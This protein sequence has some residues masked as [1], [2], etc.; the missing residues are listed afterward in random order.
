MKIIKRIFNLP[1][2][3]F[4]FA[5]YAVLFL[6]GVNLHEITPAST[7]RSLLLSLVGA[8][9]LLLAWRLLTRSWAK[10]SCPR[11]GAH[12]CVQSKESTQP[13]AGSIHSAHLQF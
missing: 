12:R 13:V 1:L 2:H 5:G 10:A 11:A 6:L 8:A 3:P 9:V 4:F 7:L